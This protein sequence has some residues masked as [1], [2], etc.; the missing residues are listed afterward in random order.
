MHT[1]PE[2]A[3]LLQKQAVAKSLPLIQGSTYGKVR[4]EPYFNFDG[5]TFT[6]EFKI[7]INKMYVLK[8]A[9]SFDVHIANQDD[10]KYGKNLQFVHTIESFAEESRPLAKF[11]CKWA[12]NNR[13]FHRSSSYYGYYMGTLE[14]VRHLELSGNE[15]AE[16]LLLMEG[17][18]LQ[19]ESIGTRNTTWEITREHLPRKMTITGAKQGIELKVSKFTCAA[20][21][22]QYKICFYDKKIY[23]ENVEELIEYVEKELPVEQSLF[24][25]EAVKD[26]WSVAIDIGV[27]YTTETLVATLLWMPISNGRYGAEM[28][29]P[30]SVAKLATRILNIENDNVADFCCGTGNFLME[31]IGASPDSKYYGIEINT[32]C[33]EISNIRL[34]L[35]SE[36]VTI[37]QGNT[38]EMS[39]AKKFD[40]I[41]CDYPWNMK[42]FNLGKEKMQEFESV[43]PEIKKVANADWLFILNAMKHLE[44]DGKAVVVTTNGTTWNGGISKSIREKFVK[45][46]WI[47]AVISLPGNLYASTSIPTS[48]LVLSKGNKSIRMIDAS[49]MAA[50]GR[51]Q[52]LLSDETIESIVN[53]FNEDTDNAKSVTIEEIQDQ[54]YAINPSRFLEVEIEVEDGVPFEDLIVNVTRGAQVKA[55]ELDEM[56]SEEP[57]DYQYLMLANIQDGIISDEL[58]F[59]KSMDKK[60]EKYCIKNNSL[61]ISKNGAPVKIAVASVEE[62]RKI[63]ANGNLYVIELDETKV[64]PYF[65]KAYLESE[66]GTIALS[67]VTVGA[68]LPNIPVDGLKKIMIPCPDISVQNEVAEKYLAKMD[69]VKILKHKLARATAELKSIYEEG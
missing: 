61:V 33:K 11:I 67:R 52:N 35:I 7:G 43:I 47:E 53:M 39:V 49:E 29:T 59:L 60:M 12:D 19:G 36:Q 2:L 48:L 17:K 15:L 42:V 20:N 30:D 28:E 13:Q 6:V 3:S 57:T 44:K 50:V 8:D 66:N 46:G 63:L 26:A 21:T 27:S 65:V 68:T 69:E 23:I 1:T 5:R 31:A 4:L 40:K 10:Y 62:G 55:N 56:V 18:T 16:F 24:V 45:L 54:D 37:E 22:E 32:H 14:K 38:L 58:P 41:F 25:R 9:F 51:R 34:Q 64:N